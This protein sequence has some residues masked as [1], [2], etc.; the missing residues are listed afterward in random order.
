M[1]QG[2]LT[3]VTLQLLVHSF[4]GE[5]SSLIDDEYQQFFIKHQM[6][7]QGIGVCVRSLP[8]CREQQA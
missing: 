8:L 2:G 7:F 3:V 5:L 4:A 1:H 6:Q